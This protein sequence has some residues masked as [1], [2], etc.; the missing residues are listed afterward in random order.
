MRKSE[1]RYLMDALGQLRKISTSAAQPK[2]YEV[3][4]HDIPAEAGVR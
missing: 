4:E 2:L 3:V 1:S